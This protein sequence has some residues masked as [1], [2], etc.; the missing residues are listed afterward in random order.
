MNANAGGLPMPEFSQTTSDGDDHLAKLYVPTD[1]E[2]WFKS[3]IRNIRETFHPPQVT[4]APGHVQAG[5][6]QGYLGPLR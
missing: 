4:A 2:P 3:L 6:G 5:S 1:E